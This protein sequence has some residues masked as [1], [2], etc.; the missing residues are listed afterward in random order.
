MIVTH[1]IVRYSAEKLSLQELVVDHRYTGRQHPRY[2]QQFLP[3]NQDNVSFGRSFI[4]H[5]RFPINSQCE[6]YLLFLK[7]H[8]IDLKI[9]TQLLYIHIWF[10]T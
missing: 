2:E 8:F 7:K 6:F 5:V 4:N 1:Y 3:R 10:H 9:F